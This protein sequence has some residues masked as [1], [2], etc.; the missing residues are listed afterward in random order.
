MSEQ[1]DELGDTL[2]SEM[3]ESQLLN[4]INPSLKWPQLLKHP[5]FIG[6]LIQITSAGLLQTEEHTYKA[7]VKEI[8]QSINNEL[9][10]VLS[11]INILGR[12]SIM[13]LWRVS[14]DN[15]RSVQLIDTKPNL[16]K[17]FS[18]SGSDMVISSSSSEISLNIQS[19]TP[20]VST[21]Q[22][23]K[24]EQPKIYAQLPFLINGKIDIFYLHQIH[25]LEQ[26][27][28]NFTDWSLENGITKIMNTYHYQFGNPVCYG[29]S[30]DP[31]IDPLLIF[32]ASKE[33]LLQIRMNWETTFETHKLQFDIWYPLKGFLL[34]SESKQLIQKF[35]AEN[36][37][38]IQKE[39]TENNQ[40]EIINESKSENS[41]LNNFAAANIFF[42]IPEA[43]TLILDK[44]IKERVD[45]IKHTE[46]IHDIFTDSQGWFQLAPK[47]WL[48]DHCKASPADFQLNGRF[49]WL[50][51]PSYLYIPNLLLKQLNIYDSDE[52]SQ[53]IVWLQLQFYRSQAND[54]LEKET[55]EDFILETSM[56]PTPWHVYT[57]K[58]YKAKSNRNIIDHIQ[59]FSAHKYFRENMNT[60]SFSR[61]DIYDLFI[62]PMEK[63]FSID[64]ELSDTLLQAVSQMSLRNGIYNMLLKLNGLEEYKDKYFDPH[65]ILHKLSKIRH[66]S[67]F[68]LSL[69]KRIKTG[70][71][72][73]IHPFDV[74]SPNINDVK[75]DTT[76]LNRIKTQLSEA[77]KHKVIEK[78]FFLNKFP[79]PAST[80]DLL[81]QFG[82]KNINLSNQEEIRQ[83]IK[84]LGEEFLEKTASKDDGTAINSRDEFLS[85]SFPFSLLSEN[86]P[87]ARSRHPPLKQFITSTPSISSTPS[88]SL[89]Q[90]TPSKH[91]KVEPA[92]LTLSNISL[93][94]QATTQA[95]INNIFSSVRSWCAQSE[96]S[97]RVHASTTDH[98]AQT[99][100]S[101]SGLAA[102]SQTPPPNLFSVHSWS[103]LSE[104]SH[105]EHDAINDTQGM[106][107][108]AAQSRPL[109]SILTGPQKD[110]ILD[111]SFSTWHSDPI[112]HPS[113]TSH[114]A[115]ANMH[116]P[117]QQQ[118]QQQTIQ[119]SAAVQSR[120]PPPIPRTDNNTPVTKS[121][122]NLSLRPLRQL[123]PAR[124]MA[125]L[126]S[127]H[128][129]EQPAE[130]EVPENWTDLIEPDPPRQPSPP[131]TPVPDLRPQ[132]IRQQEQQQRQED[133][134]RQEEQ[135]QAHQQQR[136]QR[137]RDEQQLFEQ[138][139]QQ[140][141]Q[142]RQRQDY[143]FELMQSDRARY[144]FPQYNI[145][146]AQ[147]NSSYPGASQQHLQNNLRLRFENRPQAAVPPPS[148]ERAPK[149]KLNS[150]IYPWD[151]TKRQADRRETARYYSNIS[152]QELE[153]AFVLPE[154]KEPY[155]SLFWLTTDLFGKVPEWAKIPHSAHSITFVTD[156][157]PMTPQTHPRRFKNQ[158]NLCTFPMDDGLHCRDI[159]FSTM[160][161]NGNWFFQIKE[162]IQ[163]PNG[164]IEDAF[165]Y[166][167]WIKV[168][169]LVDRLEQTLHQPLPP[170]A[171]IGDTNIGTYA[172]RRITDTFQ[173]YNYYIDIIHKAH[174][175][176]WMRMVAISQETPK[177]ML[178][179]S[180]CITF[181]WHL[182]SDFI[183]RLK[184][185]KDAGRL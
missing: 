78:E 10:L 77:I 183:D 28:L 185:F 46:R 51:V 139:Q 107:S 58:F 95:A 40:G 3:S 97:H 180:G 11:H 19:T 179:M 24:F 115:Q 117:S 53:H 94:N 146:S 5:D 143:S 65:Y 96:P 128:N 60:S 181:P 29:T 153:D 39:T 114:T 66:L 168:S 132:F 1:F 112:S 92:D 165:I 141:Q 99:A 156:P 169:K 34:T 25:S 152:P 176:G 73:L 167:E 89:L 159:S 170:A 109:F 8:S 56:S 147:G 35:Q 50:Y 7:I 108:T 149:G 80:L 166:I 76:I 61:K 173:L 163:F 140:Q 4:T 155:A 105:E 36:P 30:K 131:T 145:P 157:D 13:E 2:I 144:K 6:S 48:N 119:Y 182:L 14:Y 16:D 130:E 79:I 126:P 136:E 70:P 177:P 18:P 88:P 102:Q 122:G 55:P 118:L 93:H 37:I 72:E 184:A 75:F 175:K 137:R 21:L 82:G 150:T 154:E 121:L 127:K 62:R 98:P 178:D 101:M 57:S 171:E 162:D 44:E 32:P 120:R 31:E 71:V 100:N 91:V 113:N 67:H 33:E 90:P 47:T 12:K 161:K 68:D 41:P 64:S 43:V 84:T 20:T 103:T 125:S 138:Q 81:S 164:S 134:K 111:F 63:I 106:G 86:N 124:T 172:S 22:P 133:H 123:P 23:S 45:F 158:T 87:F 116:H 110:D 85:P 49:A 42:E 26:S 9:V 135:K 148:F 38:S 104:P 69:S 27:P 174:G 142:H 151:I 54:L 15:I 83:I 160:K 74:Y 129:D 59:Q 52:E 17:L